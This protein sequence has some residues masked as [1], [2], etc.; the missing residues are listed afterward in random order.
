MGHNYM[1][2]MQS[3]KYKDCT[4]NALGMWMRCSELITIKPTS[5]EETAQLENQKEEARWGGVIE[6]GV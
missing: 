1:A 3:R 5:K 2:M 6:V 4:A